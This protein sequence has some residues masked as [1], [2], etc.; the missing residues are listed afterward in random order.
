[1]AIPL[2]SFAN[3]LTEALQASLPTRLRLIRGDWQQYEGE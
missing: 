3:F 1:L 2:R